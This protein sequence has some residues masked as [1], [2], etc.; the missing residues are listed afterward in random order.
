MGTVGYMSPEQLRGETVDG[1]ADIFAF[2]VILY[3]M[4]TGERPFRGVSAAETMSAIL[5]LEAPELTTPLNAQAPGL[6][7][8]IHRCLEKQVERRFQSASDLGFALEA[9]TLPLPSPSA[10]S[11]ASSSDPATENHSTPTL[12]FKSN[13]EP[14]EL[15]GLGGL[16][17]GRGVYDRHHCSLGEIISGVRR[18]HQGLCRSRVSRA[19][20]EPCLLARWKSNRLHMGRWEN[21]QRGVYVKVIGEGSPLR[22]AS[23]PSFEV[24]WSPDGRSIA[25]DRAG[26][27][28]GIFTVPATGGTGAQTH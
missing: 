14:D 3:E 4:L 15:A 25:F 8:L 28:G 9:M 10:A 26:D 17:N 20:V 12:R 5:T 13:R 1:R 18:C 19:K 11:Q 22:V 16:G 6:Q 2:G 21:A 24:A 7:R 27:D 23:N